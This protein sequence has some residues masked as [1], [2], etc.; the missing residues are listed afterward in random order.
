MNAIH[1][2]ARLRA[3]GVPVVSSSD[4]AVAL[5]QLPSATT[6]TLGRLA[7]VGLVIRV[8]HGHWW[9]AEGAVDPYRLP[10]QLTAPFDSYLS[11]Y[12]ALQLHGMIE[13]LP[14]VYYAVTQARTQQIDTVVGRFSF[15]HVLPELFGGFVETDSGAKIATPEKALFDVA[16]LSSGRARRFARLPELTLPPRFKRRELQGWADRVPSERARTR[17]RAR[18][19]ELLAGARATSV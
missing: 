9:I 1:A 18:L 4:A 13:Q 15:H 5:G 10:E 11:L 3:L 2:L 12:T 19:D 16:W 7:E 17:V 6:R 8:R 14:T